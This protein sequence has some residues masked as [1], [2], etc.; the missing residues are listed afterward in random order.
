MGRPEA[1]RYPVATVIAVA[2][3]GVFFSILAALIDRRP[4]GETRTFA[5]IIFRPMERILP[6]LPPRQKPMPKELPPQIQIAMPRTTFAPGENVLRPYLPPIDVG[7]PIG[8][9]IDNPPIDDG[10]QPIYRPDPVYPRRMQLRGIEGWVQ[11]KFDI[12]ASGA[13]THVAIVE[14]DPRGSFDSAAMRAVAQWK[15]EPT[16]SR[17]HTVARRDVHVVLRFVLEELKV[18]VGIEDAPTSVVVAPP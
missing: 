10:P 11:L 18:A 3:M 1:L 9:P 16:A 17:G 13:V 4:I 15:Y 5:R 6:T 12:E 7:G 14:A 2:V 8:G